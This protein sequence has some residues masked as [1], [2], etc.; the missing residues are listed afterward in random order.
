MIM[1]NYI[2]TI[3]KV[4]LTIYLLLVLIAIVGAFY[5]FIIT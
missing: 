4:L 3:L 1:D 5:L 2:K